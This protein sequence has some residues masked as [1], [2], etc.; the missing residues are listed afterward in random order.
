MQLLHFTQTFD[1]ANVEKA[2]PE[3]TRFVY[4][5]EDTHNFEIDTN[6]KA[7]LEIVKTLSASYCVGILS[8]GNA[9]IN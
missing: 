7:G 9:L 4:F 1:V 5:R 2:E 8:Q 6:N 3:L